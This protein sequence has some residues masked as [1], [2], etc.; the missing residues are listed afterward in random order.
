MLAVSKQRE[1]VPPPT[2]NRLRWAP[3]APCLSVFCLAMYVGNLFTDPHPS[4]LSVNQSISI[5]LSIYLSVIHPPI[6]HPSHPS[7]ATSLHP[8][9][10]SLSQFLSTEGPCPPRSS[11]DR[12]GTSHTPSCAP[13]SRSLTHSCTPSA[14]PATQ[15]YS[16]SNM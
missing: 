11:S 3:A 15:C 12:R 9:H 10:E 14:L 4:L 7:R 13:T 6:N 5:H 16:V 2:G 1:R 8:V